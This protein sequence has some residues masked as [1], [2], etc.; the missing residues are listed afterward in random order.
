MDEK[1]LLAAFH[2]GVSSNLFIHKLYDQE[3]QTMAELTH[4]TQ[5]FMNAKDAIIAKRKKK[6]EQ[7]EAE[8]TH[9]LELGLRPKK[10]RTG[11]KRD[12]MAGRQDR[13]QDDI[14]LHATKHF[15]W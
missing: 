13:P 12:E 7:A 6:A 15:T 14:K 11:E 8:Y 3:P 9:H 4:L 2:N 1:I 5:N 10:A